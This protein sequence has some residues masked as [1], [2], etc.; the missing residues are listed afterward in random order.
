MNRITAKFDKHLPG[1]TVVKVCY[2]GQFMGI[3]FDD[4]TFIF[5]SASSWA[6]DYGGR[7]DDAWKVD[8]GLLSKMEYER[9]QREQK[10]QADAF[11]RAR[12][13][14]KYEELKKVFE[15]PTP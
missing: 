8:L 11:H 15:E 3:V 9:K 12:M 13:R 10:K 7:I 4:N 1:K 2:G 14:E 6:M 5:L